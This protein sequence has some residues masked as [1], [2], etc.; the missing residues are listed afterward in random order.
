MTTT[1]AVTTKRPIQ[2]EISARIILTTTTTI[3]TTKTSLITFIT[4]I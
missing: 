3:K 2:T 4:T 1:K